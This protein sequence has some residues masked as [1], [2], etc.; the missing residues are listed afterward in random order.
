[1]LRNKTKP[2]PDAR[3]LQIREYEDK[4]QDMKNKCTEQVLHSSSQV[5]VQWSTA[6]CVLPVSA[7]QAQNGQCR[8][9]SKRLSTARMNR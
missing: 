2:P 8:K 9:M 7:A 4:L 1:M 5:A 6:P 3:I